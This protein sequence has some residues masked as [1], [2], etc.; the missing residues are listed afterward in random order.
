VSEKNRVTLKICGYDFCISSEDSQEYI[1][2]IGQKVEDHIN[3]LMNYSDTMSTSMAAM[4]TAL[5]YCDDAVKAREAADNLRSQI[6]DY[7]EDAVRAKSEAAELRR[8]EQSLTRE[9]RELHAK[10]DKG[11][12]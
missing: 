9:L 10:L 1:K 12:A 4:F 6:K 5:E 2:G 8:R 3:R 7:L 11:T